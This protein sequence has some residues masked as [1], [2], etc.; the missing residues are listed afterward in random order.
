[1]NIFALDVSPVTSAEIQHDKHVVKMILESAQMLCSVFDNEKYDD[2]PYKRTHYNHPCT[3]WTR[4]GIHNFNWLVVHGTALCHEYTHRFKK[5]HKSQDVI[6]WCIDNKNRLDIPNIRTP[7][8]QAMPDE[9]K[10]PNNHAKAYMDYY[11]ATK[12]ASNPK[13]TNRDV[14]VQFRNHIN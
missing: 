6:R 5:V 14:P 11:I 7:F 13:W 8:A 2:I 1:M 4:T 10:H 9:Y 12:L 3:V